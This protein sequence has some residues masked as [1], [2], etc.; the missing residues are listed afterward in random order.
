MN[1]QTNVRIDTYSSST[2]PNVSWEYAGKGKVVFRPSVRVKK[3]NQIK[4]IDIDLEQAY[5]WTKEWQTD[6]NEAKQE[7]EDDL[8]ETFD[9]MDE[10]LESLDD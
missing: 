10:F 2:V 4:W 9:T 8:G 1:T 6:F 7:L 3:I 5:F